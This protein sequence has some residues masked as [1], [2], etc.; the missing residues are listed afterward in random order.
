MMPNLDHFVAQLKAIGVRKNDTIVVYDKSG[1]ICAPRAYWMLKSFGAPNV[2]V[3]N[4]TF[5]KWE[6]EKRHVESG[7]NEHTWQRQRV[8]K[9][10]PSDYDFKLDSKQVRSYD[11]IQNVLNAK[12]DHPVHILDGRG[13]AQYDA[14]HI[15][16]AKLLSFSDVLNPDKTF[17]KVEELKKLFQEQGGL[18]DPVKDE[19]IVYCQR[20]IVACVLEVAL[21][22]IGNKNSSVY[23]GSYEEYGAKIKEREA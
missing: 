7:E 10:S 2:F 16:T 5:S 19:V 1:M 13:K 3:L 8:S 9:I 15:E 17:K 20:A 12:K 14:G 22:E 4:G 21:K 18:A 23:D 6:A 11:D